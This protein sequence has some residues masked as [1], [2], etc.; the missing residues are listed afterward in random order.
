MEPAR[1]RAALLRRGAVVLGWMVFMGR[2]VLGVE[3]VL[4]E[5]S[6]AAL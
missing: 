2:Q 4:L 5:G 1:M 6:I 3:W